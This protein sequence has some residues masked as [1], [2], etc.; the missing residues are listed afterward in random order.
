MTST[1]TDDQIAEEINGFS[2]LSGPVTVTG[3]GVN[4]VVQFDAKDGDVAQLT[5]VTTSAAGGTGGDTVTIVTRA[6]GWS[7]EAPISLSNAK[8]AGLDTIQA[9]GIINI[10]TAE[11]CTFTEVSAGTAGQYCYD[12]ICGPVAASGTGDHHEAALQ[13]I[14]DD[15][16][17]AI[18]GTADVAA[19][20]AT[21]TYAI[22]MPVGKSCDGLELRGSTNPVTKTVNKNNNGKLFKIKRSF[23]TAV[24]SNGVLGASAFTCE[25]T[26]GDAGCHGVVAN[27][28]SLVIGQG[29]SGNCDP[30]ILTGTANADAAGLPIHRKITSIAVAAANAADAGI[31]AVVATG[32]VLH[33]DCTFMVGRH[34]ITLDSAPVA[35]GVT[36]TKS[37]EYTSPVG[38]CSVA[39]TTKGTYESFECSNRG[40]CDG[41]SGLCT[42]YEGYSGQS[43][44]TQT[45][46]V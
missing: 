23:S 14:K 10:T 30:N 33:T 35:S 44:Q 5:A 20:G 21:T 28:D 41:K 31:S 1:S 27:V 25:T 26:S 37:L 19:T 6:H 7:I 11:T 9:G 39:E 45:V 32:D 42:C 40:A 4:F 13:A 15:N 8:L 38:S 16:G 24:V 29:V 17:D 34:V 3:E 22:T 46:L 2:A 18:L 43:C 12:G 36:V